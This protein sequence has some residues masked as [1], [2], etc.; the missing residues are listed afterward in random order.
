MDN[1]SSISKH[2]LKALHTDSFKLHKQQAFLQIWLPLVLFMLLMTAVI[3]LIIIES[4]SLPPQSFDYSRQWANISAMFLVLIAS[5]FWII[6]VA[7][8]FVLI[9]IVVKAIQTLPFYTKMAQIYVNIAKLHLQNWADKSVN[10]IISTESRN[11]GWKELLSRLR[12]IKKQ[13]SN[14]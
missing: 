11:A 4:S 1:E 5:F 13:K 6:N 9:F 14:L 3:V 7:V 2:N 12:L 8:L 10:P